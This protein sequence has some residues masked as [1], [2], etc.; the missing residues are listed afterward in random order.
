MICLLRTTV[1]LTHTRAHTLAPAALRR[2]HPWKHICTLVLW[3]IVVHLSF[4]AYVER[5]CC[6]LWTLQYPC[7]FDLSW[8]WQ[9]KHIDTINVPNWLCTHMFSTQTSAH[10]TW[11]NFRVIQCRQTLPMQLSWNHFICRA[12]FVS[13][14]WLNRCLE[15]VISFFSMVK[16]Q[17]WE[18]SQ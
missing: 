5:K 15:E 1:D 17:A 7:I 12:S 6:R 13:V 9:W 16:I 2:H 11:C 14:W 10:N 18:I 8:H 3:Y 4:Q